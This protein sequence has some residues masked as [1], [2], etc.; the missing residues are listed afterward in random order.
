MNKI[1]FITLALVAIANMA[2]CQNIYQIRADS[3][4]IYNDCDTAELIIENHTQSVPGFLYNKGRGRTEFRRLQFLNL[5]NGIIS[6]GDQDT[7]DLGSSLSGSFIRNQ[8]TAAQTADFWVKGS[9][10]IDSTVVLGRYKNNAAG[11][12]VLTTDENGNLKL[13]APGTGLIYEEGT[14][15]PVNNNAST[16]FPAD[17][18]AS[19]TPASYVRIG[20][21]VTVF[22]SIYV[23]PAYIPL[24]D[25]GN[26]TTIIITGL[27]FAPKTTSVGGTYYLKVTNGLQNPV[28]ASGDIVIGSSGELFVSVG[29]FLG[30]F[31]YSTSNATLSNTLYFSITYLL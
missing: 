4:R 14:W 1:L 21:M 20:N 15:T 23:K 25:P 30:S 24:L 9:G 11:D 10:R 16:T 6:I 26:L 22:A 12:S 31:R 27:P 8:K 18:Y 29:A 3:V 17:T 13:K 7:L 19:R 2:I 5:G 28:L